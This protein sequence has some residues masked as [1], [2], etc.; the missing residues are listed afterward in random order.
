MAEAIVGRHESRCDHVVAG[1]DRGN[2]Q[3]DR[4]TNVTA[5]NR[6][7]DDRVFA[8]VSSTTFDN[9]FRSSEMSI[10]DSI[11]ALI[12]SR[13]STGCSERRALNHLRLEQLRS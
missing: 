13:D 8:R 10:D 7:S 4:N 11:V 3:S 12:A 2:F 6:G 9:F 5:K 1:I